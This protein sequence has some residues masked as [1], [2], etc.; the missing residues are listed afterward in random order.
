MELL[1][2]FESLSLEDIN[3]YLEN[4]QEENLNV[5]LKQLRIVTLK[6][7]MTKET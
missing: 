4:K 7:L 6:A 1:D 5:S 2:K 3:S